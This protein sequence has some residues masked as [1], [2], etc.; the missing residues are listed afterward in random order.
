MGSPPCEALGVRGDFGLTLHHASVDRYAGALDCQAR[1]RIF[2]MAQYCV[3][4]ETIDGK[5]FDVGVL[6]Y[7]EADARYAAKLR[8]GFYRRGFKVVNVERAGS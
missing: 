2:D 7:D 3:I 5:R 4:G 8:F 1:E 6:A